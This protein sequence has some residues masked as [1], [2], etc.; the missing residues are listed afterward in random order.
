MTGTNSMFERL[1]VP[2]ARKGEIYVVTFNQRAMLQGGDYLL[3]FG[4]TG[5][6]NGEFTVYDRMY[7]VVNL[8]I[9]SEQDTVGSFDIDSKVSIEKVEK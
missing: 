5:Y 6:E 3:S 8:T 4:C 2:I 9:V 1:E 7:D